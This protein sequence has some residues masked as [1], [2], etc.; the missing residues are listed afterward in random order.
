MDE[1][2][3]VI[4]G[5][6]I[7][8][9]K[10]QSDHTVFPHT[11]GSTQ[12]RLAV[13]M[14]KCLLCLAFLLS[15][16]WGA[17]GQKLPVFDFSAGSVAST[18]SQ[19]PL[20]ATDAEIDKKI[21]KL[22]SRLSDLQ[23]QATPAAEQLGLLVAKPDELRKQ[24]RLISELRIIMDKYVQILR[25]LKEIRKIKRDRTEEIKAWQGFTEKPPFPISFLD[26]LRDSILSHKLDLQTLQLRLTIAKG[27]LKQFAKNLKESGKEQRLAEERL[28]KNTG[29]PTQLRQG[30]LRQLTQLQNDLNEV[31]VASSETQRLVLEEAIASKK[32]Y[33]RFLEQKLNVADKVSPLTKIDLEQ[34][35]Q[36]LDNQ[37]R[38]LEDELNS[39][40]KK[41]ADAKKEFQQT[42]DALGQTQAALEKVSKPTSKQLAELSRL[43]TAVAAHEVYA[44]TSGAKIELLKGMLQ[45]V[46]ISNTMWED[47]FW[48][49]QNHDLLTMKEKIQ[50]TQ[51]ILALINLWKEYIRTRLSS[52]ITLVQGQRDKLN[53]VDKRHKAR[54][55]DLII[56]KAY[57]ERQAM[58]LRGAESLSRVERLANRL[59][60]EL[61]DRAEHAPFE[62]RLREKVS[63]ALSFINR[64]WNT[65]LYVAEETIIAEGQKIVNPISVTVGKVIKALIILIA[66]TWVSRR[67][68]KPI[69]WIVTKRFKKDESVSQQVGKVT[70]LILFVGVLVFSLISVNI[71]LAVFAFLG[72]ALAIGIGFGAQNLINN[73]ISSLILLFDRSISVGDIVEIDGQGGRVVS[74]GMRSSHIIGYDGI[75]FLVP[76][77]QFLQ[78]KVTNWTLSDKRRRY[79]I[80]VGVAYGSPTQE[81]SRQLL[82]AVG[83]NDLVLQDP[84]PIVLFE[85]F[86]DSALIFSVYFW[87]TLDPS[88]DNRAVLS[89]IRHNITELLGRAGIVISFQQ[90]DIH[91]DSIRPIEIKVVSSEIGNNPL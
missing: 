34:K 20:P 18:S 23:L 71:P 66:G 68:I 58:L 35:L 4:T 27:D 64:V 13:L 47:R 67:L 19:T 80:S 69:Q 30:W 5:T 76:N 44:E 2:K 70:F 10:S 25:E 86:A 28:G 85:Q 11:C 90:R 72:G 33:I 52:W 63:M 50:Q 22:E 16:P 55:A 59:N 79:S 31:G 75:E 1:K 36:E 6:V 73:F 74:I 54:Q 12:E 38:N 77:S 21:A 32:E 14:I 61:T 46:A 88:T 42:R 26:G 41:D 9:P 39:A 43:Q 65:E 51:R 48:I 40:Q 56:L 57:E 37:R 17:S 3:L 82:K 7:G 29:T 53:E 87:L 49:T 84:L 83:E 24:A 15:C 8:C 78:H 89:D 81:V 91:V 45:L 60:D 62:S